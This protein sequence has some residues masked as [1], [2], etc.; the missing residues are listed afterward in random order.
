LT[1]LNKAEFLYLH[2]WWTG[3]WQGCSITGFVFHCSL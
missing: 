2:S 3:H 1:K